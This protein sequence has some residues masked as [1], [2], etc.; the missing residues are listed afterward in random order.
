MQ[1]QNQQQNLHDSAQMPP[2]QNHGGHALF[3][4]HEALGGFIG[5]M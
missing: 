4:T 5:G 1:M 2:Q 3:D